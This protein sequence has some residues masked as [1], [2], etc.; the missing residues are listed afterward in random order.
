MSLGLIIACG[1]H[2]FLF[3]RIEINQV[4]VPLK[5]EKSLTIVLNKIP[6]KPAKAIDTPMLPLL[7]NTTNIKQ[8][9]LPNKPQ[10]K[11]KQSLK[12]TPP[13]KEKV[14][15]IRIPKPAV[16]IDEPLNI[17]SPN[18]NEISQQSSVQETQPQQT[19]P[20]AEKEHKTKT[21]NCN[22]CFL[23]PT[24]RYPFVA[25]QRGIEG[26]V[27]LALK[28]D[29]KGTVIDAKIINSDPEDVFEEAALEAV[30]QCQNIPEQF[31]N[32]TVEQTIKFKLE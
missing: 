16:S 12:S 2:V 13:K 22:N 25:K 1:V 26:Q 28:I 15:R 14:K 21:I 7:E 19:H 31:F 32:L 30:R 11:P 20:L 8:P 23:C 27:K 5:K 18:T 4:I 17:S 6:D 29:E 24:P 9:Q 10:Q 3:L